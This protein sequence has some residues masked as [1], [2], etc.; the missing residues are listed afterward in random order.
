MLSQLVEVRRQLTGGNSESRQSDRKPLPYE[1][2]ESLTGKTTASP[3]YSP[4]TTK[5]VSFVGNALIDDSLPEVVTEEMRFSLERQD[6]VRREQ[7]VRTIKPSSPSPSQPYSSP[8]E[9]MTISPANFD[10]VTPLHLLGDQPDVVDCPFCLRRSETKVN[11][12]ASSITQ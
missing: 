1:P 2:A 5:G 7:S 11:R 4:D 6:A 10:T 8:P 9:T 12:E 3:I